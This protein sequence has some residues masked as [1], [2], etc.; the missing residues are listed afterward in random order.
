MKLTCEYL[1]SATYRHIQFTYVKK[2]LFMLISETSHPR[3]P[4]FH[5][6]PGLVAGGLGASQLRA[7]SNWPT[8]R[9]VPERLTHT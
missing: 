7:L 8:L 4:H 2:N 1:C 5:K 6:K 3:N 9:V